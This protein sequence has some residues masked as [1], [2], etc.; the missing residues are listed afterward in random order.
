MRMGDG[1]P[2]HPSPYPSP[3]LNPS[4]PSS[5]LI[6]FLHLRIPPF[7]FPIQHFFFFFSPF[8]CHEVYI[9]VVLLQASAT[10]RGFL[11]APRIAS[12]TQ[13]ID[14]ALFVYRVCF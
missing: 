6:G 14:P 12:A 2:G 10:I 1:V 13:I 7:A 9:S 4:I 11:H 3:A 5:P 8:L